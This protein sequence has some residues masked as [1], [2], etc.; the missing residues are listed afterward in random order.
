MKTIT[1]LMVHDEEGV[2]RDLKHRLSELGLSFF[3]LRTFVEIKYFLKRLHRSTLIF[4]DTT[5]PDGTWADVVEV[6]KNATPP[7][8]VIVVSRVVDLALY[9]EAMQEGAADFIVAP[10]TAVDLESIIRSATMKLADGL[11]PASPTSD[12]RPTTRAGMAGA[13]DQVTAD[14][15]KLAALRLGGELW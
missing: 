1:V 8:P 14:A 2:F 12:R 3:Q 11:G 6:A 9:L 13:E 5:L 10:F 7:C 15:R 4:T